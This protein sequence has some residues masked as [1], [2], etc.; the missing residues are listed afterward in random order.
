MYWTTRDGRKLVIEDMETTHIYNCI[1]MMDRQM[2]KAI[3]RAMNRNDECYAEP[4]DSWIQ[5]YQALVNEYN[6]RIKMD[7]ESKYDKFNY[8]DEVKVTEKETEY[9]N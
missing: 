9:G 8:P 7:L 6:K 4:P 1:R 2:V 5:T 3:N